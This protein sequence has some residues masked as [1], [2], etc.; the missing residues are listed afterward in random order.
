MRSKFAIKDFVLLVLLSVVGLLVV[1]AMFQEDRR[2]N[3]VQTLQ[4]QVGEQSSQMSRIEAKVDMASEATGGQSDDRLAAIERSQAAI[5]EALQAGAASGVSMEDIQARIDELAESGAAPSRDESWARDDGPAI[6]W[7]EP[8]DYATDPRMMDGYRTGGEFIETFEAQMPKVMPFIGQDVYSRRITDKIFETLAAYDPVTLKVRGVL[9]EAWQYDTEGMWLRVKI[10]DNARFSDGEPVLADDVVYTWRDFIFN[11]VIEAERARSI[12][13]NVDE[14]VA[15]DERVVEFRFKGPLYSNLTVAMGNEV[16]PK[17]FYEQFTETQINQATSLVL[18]SGPYRLETL[19]IDDQWT[20]GRDFVLVRNE[21]YWGGAKP[22]LRVLRYNVI[23]DA[24]AS[25]TSF[26][27]GDSDMMRPTSAQFV[28]LADDPEFLEDNQA[29]SWVNMRS[30]YSFIGWQAGERNG[31]LRPFHDVRVR[32]AMTLLLDRQRIVDEIYEGVG[33]VA[34]GPNNRQSPA[35]P[36]DL[37]PWPH[38]M[39]RAQELLAEAGWIDRDNDS[40]LENEAGEEFDFEFTYAPSGPAIER[41][42]NYLVDQ[43]AAV[44]IRCRKRPTDWSIFV[45]LFNSRDFD[46]ITLGWS[47]TAPE[48]D[49]RQIFHSESIENQ[50]D[51]F[52]QWSS[53][54]ADRLIDAGRA[55]LDDAK[56]MEIWQEL[57]HI[58][59]EEQPYTFMRDVPWLRFVSNDYHNVQTYP[60]GIEQREFFYNPDLVPTPG[61]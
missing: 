5:L 13:D 49:P 17:H 51:N 22:S 7:Q 52:V 27:N 37:E 56:R 34:T 26:R 28:E 39:E 59:H 43:C 30:G 29:L 60:K 53:P 4:Q 47:A 57:A 14:V 8:L 1:L 16:L 40:I 31:K 3:E 24:L 33:E 23:D 11:P 19:N 20:P 55:E 32:Q 44:G 35:Y 48:S 18:G 21:Q 46:A 10:R 2:W 36:T 38:D 12:S 45:Q 9:A 58:L 54:E 25:L 50:G 61:L 41:L 15:I 42:A 6:Q